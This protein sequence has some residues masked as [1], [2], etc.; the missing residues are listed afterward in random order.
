MVKVIVRSKETNVTHERVYLDAARVYSHEAHKG[1]VTIVA[2]E[3]GGV[4]S[5]RVYS[6][7]DYSF[8]YVEVFQAGRIVIRIEL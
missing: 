5:K 8:V 3:A 6:L 7:I 2:P 4:Y 1:S